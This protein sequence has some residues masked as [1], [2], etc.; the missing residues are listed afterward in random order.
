[1][2]IS[3]GN[4]HECCFRIHSCSG[5]CDFCITDAPDKTE[6]GTNLQL[7]YWCYWVKYEI[8]HHGKYNAI[9]LPKKLK[10]HGKLRTF[11]NCLTYSTRKEIDYK[12]ECEDCDACFVSIPREV[13][14]CNFDHNL[15]VYSLAQYLQV[16]CQYSILEICGNLQV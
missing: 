9:H 2:N 4:L 11:D 8:K 15:W 10:H 5:N 7:T 1:M 13:N 14:A 12:D 16:L 3:R 6:K